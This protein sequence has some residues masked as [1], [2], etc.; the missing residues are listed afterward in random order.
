MAEMHQR[1]K[2]KAEFAL[3]SPVLQLGEHGLERDTLK[4]KIGDGKTRWN[5]LDYAGGGS[6]EAPAPV[7]DLGGDP[8]IVIP[9]GDDAN[10]ARPEGI[11]VGYWLGSVEPLNAIDDDLW[12][13]EV[14]VP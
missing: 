12:S 2:T 5:S 3:E 13:G 14:D 1:I 6:S 8:I 4:F 11:S 10:F 7:L 9:H